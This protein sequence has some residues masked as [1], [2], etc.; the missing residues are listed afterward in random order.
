VD[1]VKRCVGL[2][3]AL[4]PG[5]LG[6]EDGV[7]GTDEIFA[8]CH[9]LVVES[10]MV[11]VDASR[12]SFGCGIEATLAWS[13]GK[14]LVTVVPGEVVPSSMLMAISSAVVFASSVCVVSVLEFVLTRWAGGSALYDAVLD[15]IE[16]EG[17]SEA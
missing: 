15:V 3:K 6:L 13:A 16:P 14:L 8:R 2:I 5:D 7:H 12:P 9:Q 1:A 10:D 4:D 11:L 17:S